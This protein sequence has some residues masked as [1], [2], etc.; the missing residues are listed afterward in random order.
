MEEAAA[1][2]EYVVRA[3][4]DNLTAVR[5]FAEI[6]QRRRQASNESK[7]KQPETPPRSVDSPAVPV[8][9][10]VATPHAREST[11]P[12][13]VD[14]PAR[15]EDRVIVELEAWLAVLERERSAR[16]QSPGPRTR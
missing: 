6:H 4:P 8:T 13:G 7:S 12:I 9:P 5:Q 3:A 14:P 16:R 2:F 11:R 15:A 10:L 1:E